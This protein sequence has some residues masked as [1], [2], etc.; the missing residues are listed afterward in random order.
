VRDYCS[1]AYTR[2][3]RRAIL[4]RICKAIGS[5]PYKQLEARHVRKLR[6]GRAAT[7][8]AANGDVKALRMVYVWAIEE[9]H[10]DKNPTLGIRKLRPKNQGGFKVWSEAEIEAYEARHPIGTKAR[11]A[12]DL[13]LYTGVRRSDVHRL[14]PQMER[15][16]ELHFTEFKGR[17]KKP[18]A[19][20]IP[21]LPDLRKS[22]DAT[23]PL[24]LLAYLVN[25]WG[26]PF[27]VAGFGNKMRQWCDEAGLK[28]RSAHG[29]RKAGATR[30]A[31]RGATVHQLMALYGWMTLEQAEVYTREADRRKL[32]REGVQFLQK[33][34]KA[35][36]LSTDS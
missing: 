25:E 9:E 34:N 16:G 14:G 20:V 32:S 33:E 28:G 1:G 8:D 29:L 15:A 10:A 12:M 19:R 11:L 5:G 7:P 21:I 17:N 2:K 30:C 22:I 23:V 6:D 13:L 31:D 3:R 27:T 35:A 26:K 4:E 36:T 24:G 18:K